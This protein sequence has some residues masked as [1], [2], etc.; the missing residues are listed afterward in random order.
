MGDS[1]VSPPPLTKCGS[2]QIIFGLPQLQN[3]ATYLVVG[4][5]RI[6]VEPPH[7]SNFSTLISAPPLLLGQFD[8]PIHL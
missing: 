7:S 5:I 6:Y 4:Y 3:H 8:N 2:P 1:G